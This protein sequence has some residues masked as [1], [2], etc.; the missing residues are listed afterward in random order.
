MLTIKILAFCLSLILFLMVVELFR[1]EKLT[2]KYAVGW[3]FASLVAIVAV[4]FDRGLT[5]ISNWFGFQLTSN[6]IFFTISCGLI[7][8]SLVL[9]I[10][11]CQQNSRNDKMAQKIALLEN[12]LSELRKIRDENPSKP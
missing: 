7:F 2:F 8:L 10:F 12:S 5:K 1:R 3:L 9:T 6:F 4:V 11:L